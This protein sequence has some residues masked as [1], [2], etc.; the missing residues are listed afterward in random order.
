M[1]NFSWL[2]HIKKNYLVIIDII[3]IIELRLD[4]EVG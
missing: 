3:V 1:T 2:T 4:G